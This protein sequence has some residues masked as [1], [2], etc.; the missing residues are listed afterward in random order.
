MS[1]P[2]FTRV[3]FGTSKDGQ[4]VHLY[5]LTNSHGMVAKVT[6]YGAILTELHA[7]DR[8]GKMA[9]VV[10]GFDDLK[11][12]IDGN[13]F[14]GATTGRVANRIAK[15]RFTLNG[16]EY[17]LA[18]N[19]GPNALHGGLKGFDKQ[20]W[21]GEAASTDHAASVAFTYTS[22]D[23]EEG[24]PGALAVTV[25][26]TLTDD[27]ELRIDYAATTDKDT[28]VNL[29]NHSYFNLGGYN[30]GDILGHDMTI[31]AEK[32][33]ASDKELIPTG[34][35]VPVAGTPL[36]FRTPHKIGERIKELYGEGKPGGYDHNFVIDG[37]GAK[38]TKAAEAY[39][40]KSGRV[41]TTLT[42]EPGVQLY[43]ANF[44][45]GTKGKGGTIHGK[46][47]SFCL[48][49]QHYPDSINKPNFPTVV[50]KKGGKFQSSTVYRFSTRK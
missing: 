32:Y 42:T 38:L 11:S 16:V 1:K 22:P 2:S 12:Y 7:P 3:D 26:Y 15:G 10:L 21:H 34:E 45:N 14:F 36:D 28:I 19:N 47:S 29:T 27:N 20:L 33:T 8:D 50:L 5:K 40:P 39:E 43:T 48:E 49:T 6:T 35:I 44:M 9:D 25:T 30:S 31:F 24:Y 4:T 46:H 41:M 18:I 13:P 23:G 17:K 37:G